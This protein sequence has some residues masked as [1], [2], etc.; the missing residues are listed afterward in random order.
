M[1]SPFPGKLENIRTNRVDFTKKAANK[2]EFLITK[3]QEDIPMD[4]RIEE[5]LKNTSAENEEELETELEEAGASEEVISVVKSIARLRSA[6]ADEVDGEVIAKALDVEFDSGSDSDDDDDEPITKSEL[7]KLP[8]DIRKSVETLKEDRD[9]LQK[10]VEELRDDLA[11]RDREDRRDTWVEKASGLDNLPQNADEIGERLFK[12]AENLGDD[13]AEETLEAL[14]SANEQVSE[15]A[16]IMKEHGSDAVGTVSSDAYEKVQ[17]RA[18]RLV[19]EQGMKRSKAERQVMKNNPD[20]AREYRR[21]I[22]S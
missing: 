6:Y 1:T 2:W 21:E 17:K 22:N 9:E 15:S 7:D 5:I 14:R 10:S 13:E 19:E 18:D 3:N 4:E 11:E 20:L 12:I 8:E 16:E